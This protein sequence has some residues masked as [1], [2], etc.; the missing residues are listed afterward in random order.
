MSTILCTFVNRRNEER[1]AAEELESINNSNNVRGST[2]TL[3][4]RDKFM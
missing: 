2:V 1:D 4:S 3:R